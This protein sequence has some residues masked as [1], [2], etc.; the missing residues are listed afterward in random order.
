M[1]VRAVFEAGQVAELVDGLGEGAAEQESAAGAAVRSGGGE[2]AERQDAAAAA[3]R[4]HAGGG[5]DAGGADGTVE[6]GEAP[7]A[8]GGW[9]GDQRLE[10]GLG[11]EGGARGVEPLGPERQWQIDDDRRGEAG[12]EG[13]SE[14]LE[15][16]CRD[17]PQG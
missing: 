9:R 17:C 2:A 5:L 15:Q 12:L 6:H 8:V 3:E 10:D 16:L 11:P 4:G 14:P 13:R 7:A 1:F